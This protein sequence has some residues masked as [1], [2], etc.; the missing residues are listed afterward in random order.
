MMLWGVGS[1][2]AIASTSS[3]D[4]RAVLNSTTTKPLCLAAS[5]DG[6]LLAVGGCCFT[7][8]MLPGGGALTCFVPSVQTTERVVCI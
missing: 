2:G 8:C 5:E 6:R 1:G 4:L 3:L 7:G